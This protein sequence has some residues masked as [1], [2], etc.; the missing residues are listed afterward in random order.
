MG[1]KAGKSNKVKVEMIGK[2]KFASFSEN[3]DRF[4]LGEIYETL[5]IERKMPHEKI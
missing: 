3:A 1:T 2:G 5:R 4:W